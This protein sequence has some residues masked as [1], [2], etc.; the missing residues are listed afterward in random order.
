MSRFHPIAPGSKSGFGF[1]AVMAGPQ[2]AVFRRWYDAQSRLPA[3]GT[4]RDRA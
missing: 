4:G 1:E 2:R 3:P